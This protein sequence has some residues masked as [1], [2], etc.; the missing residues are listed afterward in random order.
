VRVL[1][2]FSGAGGMDYGLEQAGHE[3]VG[4][5]E[6]LERPR[7][8]LRRHYPGVPLHD[9][10]TTLDG[11]Q[12]RG[13][14]DIVSGGSP[15]QD[16]SVAG[17]GRGLAGERS[18]LFWHQCR[19]AQE[20]DAKWV[21][22]ENVPGA[23]RSN[24]GEDF[25]AVLW[26]LTGVRPTVPKN[27]WRSTGLCVGGERSAVWRVLDAQHFG[28][29]QRRRRVFVVAG[30][31]DECGLE[32]LVEREV[33]A[34]DSAPSRSQE[35]TVASSAEGGAGSD[36]WHRELVDRLNP[37]VVPTLRSGGDGG[38]PSSRGEQL[39][40]EPLV[41]H[42]NGYAR[43]VNYQEG[44]GTLRASDSGRP[45]Q[46]LIPFVKSRRAQ[47]V[48]DEETWREGGPA[49]T[50]NSFDSGDSR[51]TVAVVGF[52]WQN[53][54]GYANAKDGLG[55]TEDGVGPLS[56]SQV[57]AVAIEQ[58]LFSMT[59]FARYTEGAG[60]ALTNTM[61]KRPEN[62]IVVGEPDDGLLQVRRLTPLE[63]ERLMSWPDDWT[64]WDDEGNEV[65]NTHRYKMCGNGVVSNVTAWIGGRLPGG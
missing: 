50:L 1:S 8:V 53:G 35:Q 61:A 22:W 12:F 25:A 47:S 31:R 13:R 10:V 62:F 23:L 41:Y 42:Q 16:L 59:G 58:S 14:V 2:L 63:C 65:A 46:V 15:C 19:I 26:G 64:R 36:S 39:V 48:D 55:I 51:T 3:V 32:V 18:G 17:H 21:I 4:L 29:P 49:P 54:G 30:P 9:D 20:C 52:N 38:V 33:G 57:P 24:G 5:C 28:V 60:T 44:V 7:S 43:E 34:W 6:I 45:E 40:V 56:V 11:R 27:G 37:G